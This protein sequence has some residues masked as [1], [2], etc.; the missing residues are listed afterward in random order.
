M[1]AE[2][3]RAGLLESDTDAVL[4]TGYPNVFY[5][6]GFASSTGRLYPQNF[7][8]CLI[9]AAAVTRP[10]FIMPAAEAADLVDNGYDP[11]DLFLYGRPFLAG[12]D[13]GPGDDAALAAIDTR[14]N[15]DPLTALRAALKHAGLEAA[16]IGVD[17]SD[18]GSAWRKLSAEPFASRWND[19][20]GDLLTWARMIKTPDETGKIAAAGGLNHRALLEAFTVLGQ[21][22]SERDVEAAWRQRVAAEGGAPTF[23]MASAGPRAA[24]FRRPSHRIPASGGRFR[25]DCG[26]NLNGYCADTGGN[27]QIGARPADHELGC[28]RALTAGLDAVLETARPGVTAARLHQVASDVIRKAGIPGFRHPHVGHGIG[29]EARDLPVLAPTQPFLP[30]FADDS[31]DVELAE[32]MVLNVEVPFGIVGDGGYQHELTFLVETSGVRLL[33]PRHPYYVAHDH[34]VESIDD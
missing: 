27:V 26:L 32:G 1:N 4:A 8:W 24:I 29:V 33:T 23:F 5:G 21:G 16:V 28:Y 10:L 18:G 22:G 34:G 20:G 13:D 19:Q 7:Y 30:R 6:S 17:T 3:L 12:G 9:P 25:W 2:R 14:L 31:P 15:A 11:A